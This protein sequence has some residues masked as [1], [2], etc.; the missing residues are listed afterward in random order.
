MAF[1][2]GDSGSVRDLLNLFKMTMRKIQADTEDLEKCQ[3]RIKDGWNDDGVEEVETILRTIKKA[4]EE[5]T[6][7]TNNIEKALDA[8]AEFLEN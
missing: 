1:V 5:T 2:A 6:E 4:I 8:Y 3:K 7:S